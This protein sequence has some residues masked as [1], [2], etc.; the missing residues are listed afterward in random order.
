[1]KIITVVLTQQCNLNCSYCYVPKKNVYMSFNVWFEMY[2]KFKETNTE[3][4]QI[5]YFGGEPLLNWTLIEEITPIVQKDPFCKKI[6]MVSNCLL[7]TQ[8]KVDYIKKNNIELT[9]S[10]D[11]LWND[12][13]RLNADGSKNTN[14]HFEIQPLV[15]Q[16][17]NECN[18]CICPPN[19]NLDENYKWFLDNTGMIPKYLL[20]KDTKWTDENVEMFRIEFKKMC[21][22]F[23]NIFLTTN[24]NPIP[25]IIV[26][27]LK[28][29]KEGAYEEGFGFG[30][31][32]CSSSNSW[33]SDGK[34][35]DCVYKNVNNISCGT[36]LTLN[37][38]NCQWNKAC[39]K[40]CDAY[41]SKLDQESVNNICKIFDIIFNNVIELNNRLQDNRR[42]CNYIEHLYKSY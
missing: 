25:G 36:G 5:D 32:S 27:Y 23:E 14:K 37:C 1:M 19:L 6:A 8:E 38:E 34:E 39:K 4:Y 21:D 10:F 12:S 2:S 40:I 3:P 22:T 35:Y 42:W 31:D 26:E 16:L 28:C 41:M 11:G 18:C 33:H 15:K 24:T 17:T 29:L 20:I 30:C 13:A 7:L 9:Y